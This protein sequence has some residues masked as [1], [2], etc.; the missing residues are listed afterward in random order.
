M[1]HDER[2]SG[3]AGK[4]SGKLRFGVRRL[5]RHGA[6]CA[7]SA[8]PQQRTAGCSTHERGSKRFTRNREPTNE[9]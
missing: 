5:E 6:W 1:S 7:V 3:V 8:R 2:S 4:R 9:V